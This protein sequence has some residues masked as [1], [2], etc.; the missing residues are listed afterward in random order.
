MEKQEIVVPNSLH[1]YGTVMQTVLVYTI[2][3]DCFS[4][5]SLKLHDVVEG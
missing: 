5:G 1:F 3:C 2:L 4:V